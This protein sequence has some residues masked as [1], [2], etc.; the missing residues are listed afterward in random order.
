MTTELEIRKTLWSKILL[1]HEKQEMP[2]R[3]G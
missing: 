2:V 3:L 1:M